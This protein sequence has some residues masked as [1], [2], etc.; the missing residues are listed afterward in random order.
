MTLRSSNRRLA[1][2]QAR[3]SRPVHILAE[4]TPGFLLWSSAKEIIIGAIHKTTSDASPVPL[5][6]GR[7]VPIAPGRVLHDTSRLHLWESVQGR[8]SARREKHKVSRVRSRFDNWPGA[9]PDL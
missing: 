8:R 4:S 6:G 1:H 3:L 2:R 9:N 7:S 5:L